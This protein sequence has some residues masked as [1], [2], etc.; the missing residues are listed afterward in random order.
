MKRLSLLENLL[1]KR[2]SQK[3]GFLLINYLWS[4]AFLS[5]SAL[6]DVKFWQKN[7]IRSG[8]ISS[9]KEVE[10]FKVCK[11]ERFWY[12]SQRKGFFKGNWFLNIKFCQS[13]ACPS[14]TILTKQKLSVTWIFYPRNYFFICRILIK[15]RLTQRKDHYY[16]CF[17][18][19]KHFFKLLSSLNK[20]FHSSS[21]FLTWT[22]SCDVKFCNKIGFL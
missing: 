2:V 10:I 13:K 20:Y 4:V 16:K 8:T 17:L 3:P 9:T 15:V 1:T 18:G 19:E 22:V 21:R 12:F 11:V 7:E 6:S 5:G 14:R